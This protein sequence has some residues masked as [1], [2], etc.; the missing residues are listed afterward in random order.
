MARLYS[1]QHWSR[2]SLHL[3]LRLHFFFFFRVLESVSWNRKW[4]VLFTGFYREKQAR[5]S[6]NVFSVSDVRCFCFFGGGDLCVLCWDELKF[7]LKV[8]LLSTFAD[9]PSPSVRADGVEWKFSHLSFSVWLLWLRAC[10][11]FLCMWFDKLE[12]SSVLLHI[13][14][15]FNLVYKSARWLFS[16]SLIS[17]LQIR[18]WW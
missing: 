6:Q 17:L 1:F 2:V 11:S 3:F 12:V 16:N 8:V 10:S 9:L 18:P 7:S 5:V 15:L 4:D 13:H 14:C